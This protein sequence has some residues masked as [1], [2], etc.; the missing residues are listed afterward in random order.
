LKKLQSFLDAA[1]VE[2][3]T[4][5]AWQDIGEKGKAARKREKIHKK[6][7]KSNRRGG[8]FY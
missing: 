3:K 1:S 6:T 2:P 4:R 5:E 8:D 7:I